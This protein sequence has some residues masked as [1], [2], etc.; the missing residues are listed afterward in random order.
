M[1]AVQIILQ[2]GSVENVLPALQFRFV[3]FAW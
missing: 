1:T 3:D 2:L